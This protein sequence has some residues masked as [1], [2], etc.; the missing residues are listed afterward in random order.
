MPD[1]SHSKR[2]RIYSVIALVP[3]GRVTT[4]GQIATLAGMPGQARQVGYALAALPEENDVPWHRVINAK[5]E[6]SLRARDGDAQH[7][8]ALLENEGVQ[9]SP[10]NRVSLSRFGWQP[11]E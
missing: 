9:F 10:D 7:Q 5:G 3:A 1:P 4:Y 6:I 8:Q 2:A 11:D